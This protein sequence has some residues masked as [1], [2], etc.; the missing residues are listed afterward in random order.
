MDHDGLPSS[1]TIERLIAIP[2]CRALLESPQ[3]TI[4]RTASR[5]PKTS[6]EDSFFAETLGTERNVRSC[7][8]LRPTEESQNGMEDT[9]YEELKIIY[10]LGDGLNGWPSKFKST[11]NTF[12]Y[13]FESRGLRHNLFGG[14]P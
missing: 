1:T 4:T 5:I 14:E 10:E 6:T 11:F 13:A 2:W 12:A 3:W 7:T 9:Y 8:A